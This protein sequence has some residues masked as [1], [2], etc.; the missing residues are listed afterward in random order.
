MC[1]IEDE[2]INVLE[3]YGVKGMKWGIRKDR[4]LSNTSNN[5]FIFG[6][7]KTTDPNSAYYRKDLPKSITDEIDTYI[8]NQNHIIVGD[9]P[10][11]DSQVQD[12][13]N[14]SKYSK[15]TVYTTSKE[16]RYLAN[17]DWKYKVIDTGDLD[18]NSKEG[19]KLKDEAM[20]KDAGKGLAVILENGGASATRNNVKRLMEQNKEAKV[21]MLKSD[22]S[23]NIIEDL[24]TEILNEEV[25]HMAITDDLNDQL[26]D[27][28]FNGNFIEHKKGNG[29]SGR[30]RHQDPNNPDHG[31]YASPDAEDAVPEEDYDPDYGTEVDF[32]KIHNSFAKD[33]QSLKA[34][35]NKWPEMDA[36]ERSELLKE[37]NVSSKQKEQLEDYL[38]AMYPHQPDG[39]DK[40]EAFLQTLSQLGSSA[41]KMPAR[42]GKTIYKKYPKLSDEEL[43]KRIKR[44]K[45]EHEYSD[46]TGGT[47]YI[48]SGSEKL[49]SILQT[50]GT[51]S[52]IALPFVHLAKVK[53]GNK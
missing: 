14:N 53:S 43:N 47:K 30:Y 36:K 42:P 48:K 52:T 19:L 32:D 33:E 46:I 4:E 2:D 8:K 10:G 29:K 5:V 31:K 20:S 50:A 25:K 35:M 13:L 51:I 11:I 3:H 34:K 21:F 17:K 26:V 45:L 39:Y 22:N 37:L 23:D 15:V 41:N 7:S 24:K 18:P 44:L 38:E 27:D 28:I 16:P 1:A 49:K 6:S 40:A 12:Y 9:A